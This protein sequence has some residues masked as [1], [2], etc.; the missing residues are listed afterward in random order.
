MEK[1][2]RKS[3]QISNGDIVITAKQA[4]ILKQTYEIANIVAKA[5]PAPNRMDDDILAKAKGSSNPHNLVKATILALSELRDA[6]TVA[7][8]RGVSISTVF[9]G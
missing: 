7:Q 3:V 2:E 9:N 1:E 4:E 8:N 6:R 5:V